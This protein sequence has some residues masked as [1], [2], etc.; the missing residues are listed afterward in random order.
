MSSHK[1]SASRSP[2]SKLLRWALRIAGVLFL[3][4][5]IVGI[6]VPLL[7]TTPF[8]LLAAACF[9]RGSPKLYRWLIGHKWFGAYI[10]SYREF[11]AITLRAKVVSLVLLWAV[12]GYSAVRVVEAWWLRALLA[13][14][15][16]GV[17]V[18]LLSL[19]T[20]TREM[21][22]QLHVEPEPDEG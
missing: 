3:G 18:H 17:S 9:V 11:H 5:G 1:R 2:G 16:V 22:A 4:L 14:I 13:V 10:R 6:F 19:K 20:L 12:I 15:A 8:L 21:V 7:P